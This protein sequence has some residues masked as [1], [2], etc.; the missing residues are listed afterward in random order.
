MKDLLVEYRKTRLAVLKKIKEIEKSANEIEDLPIYKN[1]LSDI[2]YSIEWLK[3]GHEPGNY[4]A[5]DKSQCYLVDQ[6]VINK[7]ISESMYKKISTIEYSD[8]INNVNHKVNYALMRLTT[9]ELECFIMIKCEK[10]T[11]R[12]CADLLSIRIGTVQKYIERA[13]NKINTELETNI[14]IN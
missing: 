7:V 8:I 9:T 14:F 2:E 11:Y 6:Q 3:K 4:N 12:E 5:I 10:L 13:L 1:I